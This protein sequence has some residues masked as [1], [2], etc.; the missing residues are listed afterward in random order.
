MSILAEM[1]T[2]IDEQQYFNERLRM[3]SLNFSHNSITSENSLYSLVVSGNV[4]SLSMKT[5]SLQKEGLGI[6]SE[7]PLRNILFHFIVNASNCARKCIHA[8]MDLETA[9]TLSDLYIRKADNATSIEELE[10]INFYMIFDYTAR[11]HAF[12]ICN[13]KYP[14][15]IQKSINYINANL[16]NPIQIKDVA[17]HVHTSISSFSHRFIKYT[18]V[19]FSTYLMNNRIKLA[20]EYLKYSNL[21]IKEIAT[22]LSFSSP[23]YF[24]RCFKEKTGISP[25]KYR[26]C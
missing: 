8:G 5:T 15:M 25:Q 13:Y 4:E 23:S 10:E 12:I 14:E 16:H 3:S 21:S 6:L 2:V 26:T 18:G 19:S 24:T 1:E 22:N 20:K 7:N 9:Y 17:K 11:M